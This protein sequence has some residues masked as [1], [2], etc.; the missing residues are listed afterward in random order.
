MTSPLIGLVSSIPC[1]NLIDFG[2]VTFA[3]RLIHTWHLNCIVAMSKSVSVPC[4]IALE[5]NVV[6]INST[7][8]REH[9]SSGFSEVCN[10]TAGANNVAI[11]SI[12]SILE[13]SNVVQ[14]LTL[15]VKSHGTGLKRSIKY[16][17]SSSGVYSFCA[18]DTFVPK[19]IFCDQCER[20]SL[21]AIVN[22]STLTVI[23]GADLATFSLPPLIMYC[24]IRE[25]SA[26]L[27]GTFRYFG[28][29]SSSVPNCT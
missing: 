15:K 5:L 29:P 10:V 27:H 8:V 12:I 16:C 21:R 25:K 20:T 26:Y 2:L 24:A 19:T 17:L 6:P 18:G 9:Q 3:G 28:F 7:S 14:M 22:S 23:I 1:K 4:G 13:V 11:C